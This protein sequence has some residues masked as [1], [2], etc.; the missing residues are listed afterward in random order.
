MVFVPDKVIKEYVRPTGA[1]H[2]LRVKN[3]PA[4]FD[5]Q[6][7]DVDDKPR[8][9]LAYTFTVNGIR[10]QARHHRRRG[11]RR[12]SISPLAR[13]ATLVLDGLDERYDIDLG[14][15]DLVNTLRGAQ[16]RLA[17][18]GI[19]SGAPDGDLNEETERALRDFQ[20]QRGA[21]RYGHPRRFDA[22]GPAGPRV[23]TGKP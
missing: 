3:V 9:G 23:V 19:Y 21:H 15:L 14:R 6:L 16:E 5:L 7:L 13:A 18:L 10:G 8:G 11:Q 2:Q 12:E 22:G 1:Q 20:A 17:A 4:K